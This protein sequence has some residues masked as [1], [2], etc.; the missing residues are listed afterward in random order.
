M[1]SRRRLLL[2]GAGIAIVVAAV[3]T[4]F[5]TGQGS[6]HIPAAHPAGAPSTSVAATS[7]SQATTPAST[8]PASTTTAA[9]Q[10][11]DAAIP[12]ET[13]VATIRP[14]GAPGSRT[15]GGP[16]TQEVPGHWWQ[17]ASILPVIDQKPGWVEVRLAQRPNESVAWVPSGDVTLATDPYYIVVD[18]NTTHLQL[19][20]ASRQVGS[21]PAGIGVPVAPTPTGQFFVALFAES[22]SPAYGPFVMVTSA[23]SN[24]ISDWEESGDAITAIHGPL[25]SDAAIG[26]TGAR[27]SH[28]CIRLHDT[29]LVQ[30]RDV[31]AGT[32]VLIVG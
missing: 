15:P 21:Y 1:P 25:G 28:G 17:A 20:K 24:T 29:D 13:L 5:V 8:T 10:T 32:P 12:A 7:P 23:H 14:A 9:S 11:V 4:W 6:S 18:L 16:S 27:V 2:G 22:P 3:T 19:Y 31:P 26:T 30:L